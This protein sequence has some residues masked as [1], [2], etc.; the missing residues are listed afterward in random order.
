MCYHRHIATLFILVLAGVAGFAL[1]SW[2]R[3]RTP[4]NPD[5]FS[6]DRI[7]YDPS[8]LL[9]LKPFGTFDPELHFTRDLILVFYFDELSCETCTVRELQT[10]AGWYERYRDHVDFLLVVHGQ[11]PVYLHNLLRVGKVKYPILVE[12][13]RGASGL[14]RTAICILDKTRGEIVAR[15]FPTPDPN[16]DNEKTSEL[17]QLLQKKIKDDRVY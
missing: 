10:L 4:E 9:A 17:E 1:T 14:D 8:L 6:R 15:Y 16:D 5:L 13:V 3:D 12:S 2:L 11:H 7:D